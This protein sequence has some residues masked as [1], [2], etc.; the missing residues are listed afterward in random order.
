MFAAADDAKGS[1]KGNHLYNSVRRHC[2]YKL[3][4][5]SSSSEIEGGTSSARSESSS[6]LSSSAADI[7]RVY[8]EGLIENLMSLLDKWILSGSPESK[9]QAYNV[10]E[11][12]HRLSQDTELV[13]KAERLIQRAGLPVNKDTNKRGVN[14]NN[15]KRILG[16]SDDNLRRKEADER[17]RWERSRQEPDEAPSSST[18]STTSTVQNVRS[19]LSK[20]ASSSNR[21]DVLLGQV[22]PRLESTANDKA[23]LEKEMNRGASLGESEETN[24]SVNSDAAAWV[25]EYIAKAGA[26][27]AFDPDKMGIGGLDDV[28]AQVKRRIWIPLAAPPQ[29]LKELG[30]NPV[31]GLLL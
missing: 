9:K 15:N 7:N 16:H 11:Q 1:F 17:Q 20:C 31:R 23:Y 27:S 12:I 13:Q 10:L 14:N 18:A 3:L 30:I 19:A 4:S 22:D 24:V 21:P 8:V 26:G 6:S 28:L 5:S 29:L 2:A 25:S